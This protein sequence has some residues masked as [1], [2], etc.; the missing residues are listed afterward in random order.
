MRSIHSNLTTFERKLVS[1]E[2]TDTRNLAAFKR[3]LTGRLEGADKRL[4][5][6][7]RKLSIVKSNSVDR[8]NHRVGVGH[9][10]PYRGSASVSVIHHESVGGHQRPSNLAQESRGGTSPSVQE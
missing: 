1:K 7:H 2:E 3:E 9:V 6:L 8:P 10:K 5:S 4:D